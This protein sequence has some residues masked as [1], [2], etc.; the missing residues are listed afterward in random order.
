MTAQ[1]VFDDL[2]RRGFCVWRDFEHLWVEPRK[3]LSYED[4][5]NIKVHFLELR[6]IAGLTP[7]PYRCWSTWE[8][9]W[10]R[11]HRSWCCPQEK[12]EG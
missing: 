12:K 6:E 11:N 10:V 9:E 3:N 4:R 5:V 7:L 2:N 8:K 1:E